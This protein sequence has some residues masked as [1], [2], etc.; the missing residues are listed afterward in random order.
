MGRSMQTMFY[1]PLLTFISPRSKDLIFHLHSKLLAFFCSSS[2]LDREIYRQLRERPVGR[3][4]QLSLT[5]KAWCQFDAHPQV[6]QK[7]N[8]LFFNARQTYTDTPAAI[9]PSGGKSVWATSNSNNN[10]ANCMPGFFFFTPLP[11]MERRYHR[12]GA[13]KDGSLTKTACQGVT[14]GPG[15]A[16]MDVSEGP[17]T[18]CN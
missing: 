12:R 11:S 6:S 18:H 13:W 3:S 8:E 7:V 4:A 10:K 14:A 17:S 9:G 16:S 5:K 1:T 15:S 2:D